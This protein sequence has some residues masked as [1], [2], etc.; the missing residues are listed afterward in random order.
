MTGTAALLRDAET[1]VLKIGS[2]L[3]T[4]KEK[5]VIF[6]GWLD[7]LAQDVKA[8]ADKG[9][10]IVIV[11]SGAVAL[12]RN[13]VGIPKNIAP[14]SIP[15][16]LKQAA[17]AVGQFHLFN[18]YYKAFSV[19]GVQVAQVLLTMSET[20]NRRMHLNARETLNTLMERGIIPVINE[21]DTISTGEIRFGDN[22]RLASRVGQMIGAD[23]VILLSTIE[24]LYTADPNRDPKAEHISVVKAVDDQHLKM[25]GESIPGL[26][27][28]GMKSKIEAA[29]T[30]TLA[31]IPLLIAKGVELHSLKALTEDKNTKTTLF[32]AQETEVNARK[33]WIQAHVSPKGGVYIDEG[34]LKALQSGK[35]LLPIGIKKIEGKFERGDPVKIITLE[36]KQVGI[37]LTAYNAVDAA[38]IIGKQSDQIAEILGYVRHEELIHRNDMV[39]SG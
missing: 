27:T 26:S 19:L 22:D 28:G 34:A 38:K 29:R 36:G 4:D 15:L 7:A 16:E 35:S 1:I 39:L 12:G 13:A 17:S 33:K 8:L 6:Q 9:K 21:N 11:S 14:G 31:G 3:V 18:G 5:G 32:M 37:G 20:E 2:V 30:S 23:A 24:G 25:A 10:K